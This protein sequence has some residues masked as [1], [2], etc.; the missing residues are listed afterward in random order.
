MRRNSAQGREPAVP[1]SVVW[2]W[3]GCGSPASMLRP[4][5]TAAGLKAIAVDEGPQDAIATG[6]V[7]P[8]LLPE[9]KMASVWMT[10]ADAPLRPLREMAASWR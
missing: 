7:S 9:A 6:E 8:Q 4:H 1:A 3:P 2:P 10:S 5:L